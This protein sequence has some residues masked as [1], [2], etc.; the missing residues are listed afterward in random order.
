MAVYSDSP[1]A[2]YPALAR[3]QR[4][5]FLRSSV[6]KR[7]RRRRGYQRTLA[8]EEALRAWIAKP[9]ER[10]VLTKRTPELDMRFVITGE[11]I[12][13]AEAR[14]FAARCEKLY[15]ADLKRVEAYRDGPGRDMGRAPLAAVEL[16]VRTIRTRLAW[17]RDVVAG[18]VVQK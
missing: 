17:C 1:G 2:V 10:D 4:R 14:R 7:G 12:S 3:L 15:A 16:G 11:F 13:W 9:N 5:G 6:E 8:G 18:R